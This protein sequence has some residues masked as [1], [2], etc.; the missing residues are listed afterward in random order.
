MIFAKLLLTSTYSSTATGISAVD[1]QLASV[2]LSIIN[3]DG[4]NY[5][6]IGTQKTLILG[7]GG[8]HMVE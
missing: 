8:K 1:N 7:Q 2:E 5:I 3:H 4:N 6:V